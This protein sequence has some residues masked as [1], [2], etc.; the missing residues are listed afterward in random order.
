MIIHSNVEGDAFIKLIDKIGMDLSYIIGEILSINPKKKKLE[1]LLE[2]GEVRI[3]GYG[4][5]PETV[6]TRTVVLLN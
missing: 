4:E 3:I 1:V 5:Q 6:I 2:G